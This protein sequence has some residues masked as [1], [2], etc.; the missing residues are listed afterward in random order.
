MR[1]LYLTGRD[2]MEKNEEMTRRARELR[3]NM[4]KEEC[5]LWFQYLHSYPV[6]FRRQCVFGNY[7]VDFYCAKA[8]LV[9]ELDGSQHYEPEKLRQDALRTRYLE[10]LGLHVLRFSNADVNQNLRGVCQAIDLA[11]RERYM[12]DPVPE[13]VGRRAYSTY[14][15]SGVQTP[16]PPPP[17]APSPQGEGFMNGGTM[18]NFEFSVPCLFGLEGLAG[19][20]LRRLD[21]ENVR[22]ENGRVLFSGD[23]KALAKA[24]ICLRTGERVLM[25]LA[26][27]KAAT[28]EQLFQG[29]YNTNLEDFI[30]KDGNFPVK[31]H[32]LN[33][34]LMSVPDCQAIVKKAASK[35]LGEKYG[36]SWLPETGA[37]YQLQF[38]IM[39]D[40]VQLYLDTSGPGLHKRGYRA[41]GNDAPLRETLAAAMVQLTHYR[42][43]DFIW[44]PFCGSG[45]I[46]IEAAM[47]ARNKAPGMYRRFS[48]EAFGWM[49]PKLWGEVREEAK[50]REFNGKYQILGSDNDPKCISLSIANARKAGVADCISFKDG[51][52]TKM[53]LPAQSGVIICNPPYGQRMMEQQSA[54]RLY[55]AL[56]RHLKYADGWK[57]YIITSEPEF[58]H[59]FGKRADKKRKLYNGMIKC[60][61]Y[62]YTE[63]T[64]KKK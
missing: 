43:R 35:R 21:M 31:G 51:D 12:A 15:K 48:A 33:S 52:A 8:R 54:Q 63:N 42:G 37:K 23:E 27:F 3:K 55:A 26:D 46:P 53:D 30:P 40:R 11:V 59:Y 29:V 13:G 10:S 17:G 58:E 24:N 1:G 20:E 36:V 16:H 18:S 9:L 7:I 34:Q 47:I 14:Q 28:F 39:N 50:S 64:R 60:D 6:Q 45:T 61:Y 5:T 44:D 38:S 57:K 2:P 32:C 25:V 49:D 4:T 62:M 56:G 22:V 19:D 41:V